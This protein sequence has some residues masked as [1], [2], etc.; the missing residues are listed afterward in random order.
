MDPVTL[1]GNFRFTDDPLKSGYCFAVEADFSVVSAS[2]DLISLMLP[3]FDI[4]ESCIHCP[5]L[6]LDHW[7][8]QGRAK[9]GAFHHCF[10]I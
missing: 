9:R 7:H 2:L 4:L 8:T 10:D 5:I 3:K 1:A 6:H